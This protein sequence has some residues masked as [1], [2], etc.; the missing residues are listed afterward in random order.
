MLRVKAAQHLQ[1]RLLLKQ[2]KAF[3]ENEGIRFL[4]ECD[5][6]T[7]RRF[8]ESWTNKNYSARKKLEALRTF[9]RFVHASGWIATNPT[10]LI[11]P[12]KVDDPPT[13]PFTREEFERV[14]SAGDIYPHEGHPNKLYG[15]R[16]KALVLLL[17]YS[18]L[19]IADAV[20]LSRNQIE[21]GILKLRT[22]KTGTDVRVPLPPIAIAALDAIGTS[23]YYFWSGASTKKSC[24]GNYQRA[25]KKLYKLAKVDN[26][27][28]HRW[29][30]TFSVE[31]LVAG[32]PLEQVSVLL[33][34]ESVKVTQKHYAA[35][36]RARQEQLETTVRKTFDSYANRTVKN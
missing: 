21:D 24:V 27:H 22:A 33:G 19:R 29:R 7:L 11:K 9:F 12:P 6:E 8:R 32:A 25:F 26:G 31:L 17:R 18:G 28:A 2:L 1:Y 35:W 3:A 4:S 30:D 20:T 10:L 23:N 14:V 15:L 5:V 13:L 16:L 34:H 36:V